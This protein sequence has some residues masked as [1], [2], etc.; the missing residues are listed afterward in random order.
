MYLV[1]QDDYDYALEKPLHPEPTNPERHYILG[2][3]VSA[4]NYYHWM[5][6]SLPAIDWGLRNRQQ[7]D[8]VLALPLLQ[9]WQ[10][11]SLALLGHADAPRLTWNHL[12]LLAGERG[13]RRISR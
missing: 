8:A 6:Q 10:E 13:I 2:G 7:R 12:A 9:P 5:T 3:N 1:S 11:A 4:H